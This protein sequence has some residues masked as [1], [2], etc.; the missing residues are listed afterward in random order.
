GWL[1]SERE[2]LTLSS[3]SFPLVRADFYNS[4]LVSP[5]KTSAFTFVENPEDFFPP[6]TFINCLFA[7]EGE[8]DDSF[9]DC[10]FG[11]VIDSVFVKSV[12][13]DDFGF[14][15]S[16]KENSPARDMANTAL[17]GRLQSDINGKSRFADGKPDAGAYEFE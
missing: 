15:F 17:S 10:N 11:A 8:N 9:I 1:H 3:D 5:N 7:A 4:I 2:I 12:P 14:D 6:W 16:L 13:E